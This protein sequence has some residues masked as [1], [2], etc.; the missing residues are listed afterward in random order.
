[1]ASTQ[2][3]TFLYFKSLQGSKRGECKQNAAVLRI[4]QS[5][6]YVMVKKFGIEGLLTI[7]KAH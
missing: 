7:D 1:M 5:G 4:A 2:F 3:N 6:P